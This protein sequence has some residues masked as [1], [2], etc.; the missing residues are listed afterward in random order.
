[1]ISTGFAAI[2]VLV[3]VLGIAEAPDPSEA[4]RP[5]GAPPAEPVRSER[6]PA[7]TAPQ[8]IVLGL[9]EGL[10]EY[11]P[12]SST[13]HLLVAQK[14][15][16]IGPADG[17]TEAQREEAKRAADGY[18]IA[19]QAGAIVAVLGLYMRRVRHMAAGVL[20]R[21]DVGR[22]HAINLAVAFLPA[23][24]IGT[25]FNSMIREHLFGMWPIVAAWFVGGAAILIVAW[26]RR[27]RSPREGMPL[28]FLTW[29]MALLIGF[30]QC[31][32]MWPGMSR[33]LLTIVGAVLVGLTL[34][35]AVEFSFLLGVVTLGAATCYD[36]Y[37]NGWLMLEMYGPVNLMLGFTFAFLSAVIAIKWM[38]G[39]LHHHGL[40]VFGLYRVAIGIIA[41]ALI[42]LGLL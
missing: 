32:A 21:N 24:V 8:A 1:M 37:Q 34:P 11:L 19:I 5:P 35:A 2:T 26:W 36:A 10:T 38:V 4:S 41:A 13:G 15:M 18:A 42:L 17:M 14:W 6:E 28:R 20:G 29:R 9:I 33:S 31:I 16:G 25:L 12:I 7:M 23:A 30:A 22:R 27:G 3:G 40:A 39:Y